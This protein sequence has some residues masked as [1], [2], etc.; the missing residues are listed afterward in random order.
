MNLADKH[1]FRAGSH[2]ESWNG[3]P[4]DED[5]LGSF[6]A[7]ARKRIEPANPGLRAS[8]NTVRLNSSYGDPPL[9]EVTSSFPTII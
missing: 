8:S 4:T 1:V 7:K 2:S 5:D 3:L 6:I 9:I